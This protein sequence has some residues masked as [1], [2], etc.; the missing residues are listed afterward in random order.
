MNLRF[1]DSIADLDVLSSPRGSLTR[2]AG[3][4]RQKSAELN[5][6]VGLRPPVSGAGQSGGVRIDEPD[7]LDE[8]S[9]GPGVFD[10]EV[11]VA[12]DVTTIVLH[13]EL[14]ATACDRLADA[15]QLALDQEGE[16]IVLDLRGLECIDLA[17]V[18]VLLLAHL[19]ASDRL[20]ELLL[21]PASPAA[22]R[23]ID[24]LHGPF[25][26]INE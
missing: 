8:G 20:T 25:V 3:W 14:S 16:R 17:G 22:Q 11:S 4:L 15:V 10:V 1:S 26:Y 18:H 6:D 2:L 9:V 23:V 19:R 13:G 7:V 21:I 5:E 24:A 12:D